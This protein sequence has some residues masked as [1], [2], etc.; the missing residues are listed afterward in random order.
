MWETAFR[1]MVY[2]KAKLLGILFGII[3]SVFLIGAQMGSLEGIIKSSI[4][5]VNGN[6]EYVFVVNN[7]STSAASLVDL[8]TRVGNEVQSIEGVEKVY[9]V[10]VSVGNVKYQSGN[11]NYCVLVGVEDPDYAGAPKEYLP[12]SHFNDLQNEGAVI[13]DAGDL[14]NMG[15]AKLGDYFS[16]NNTRV[17]ISRISVNNLGLGTQNIVTTIERARKLTNMSTNKVSAFLIKTNSNDPIINKRIANNITKSIP[18]VNAYTGTDFSDISKTYMETS[19]GIV[20]GFRI[21]VAFALITGLIIVALTMYSSVND[22]IKDYGTIKAIGGTNNYI[23]KM[24]MTQSI[25]YSILGFV[26]AL[27]LLYG[28]Q[29]VMVLTNNAMGISPSLI[30]FLLVSTLIISVVSSYFSLRKIL[31]LEP[32]EIFRM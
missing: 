12:G 16:I 17:Y 24:I 21:L 28:L 31:K 11:T 14:E 32:V 29:Y 10:V 8:D 9:P 18:N 26:F 15:N 13:V 4:G 6:E 25:I 1:F 27:T 23:S 2:D 20:I 30:V 19:S 22:R 5:I 7:K 3:I